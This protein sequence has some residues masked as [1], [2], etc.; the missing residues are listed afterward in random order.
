MMDIYVSNEN[1]ISVNGVD[2]QFDSTTSANSF[3]I[4]YINSHKQVTKVEKVI[5]EKPFNYELQMLIDTYGYIEIEELDLSI[6]SFNCLKRAGIH[7]IMDILKL[8]FDDVCRIR[9]LGSRSVREIEEK[10]N[11][12]I[13]TN[14]ITWSENFNVQDTIMSCVPES[15]QLG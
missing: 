7:C 11:G 2:I 3:L 4:D 8:D 13:R 10:V 12:Y 5:I 1:L 9:N 15:N 14:Y 6:R